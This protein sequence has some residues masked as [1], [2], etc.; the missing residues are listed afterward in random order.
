[1]NELY[2]KYRPTK[3]DRIVGQPTAVAVLKSLVS[4]NKI[5]HALLLT[6]PSGCG[7]TTIARIIRK[8]LNCSKFDFTEI[9]G[10]DKN[11]V[12]D[13][14]QIKTR[15]RAAPLGGDSRVW[16]IDESHKMSPQAQDAFLKSLEDTPSHVYFILATTDPQKLKPTIRTRCTEIIVRSLSNKSLNKLLAYVCDKEDIE[17]SEEVI[18]KIIE[19]SNGSARKALVLLNQI[20]V[21]EDEEEM[22]E[23]IKAT[24]VEEQGKLIA[25]AL[26]NSRTK[27]T[28]MAIILKKTMNEEPESIRWMILGYARNVMLSGGKLTSRAYLITEAFRDNF[29]DSKWTGVVNACYEIIVGTEE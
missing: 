28:E 4:K 27:W 13:I 3:L 19:Y 5:P 26:L 11:G 17:V 16:L 9:D 18:D 25:K 1:M 22:L 14:R 12:D 23:A 6:G 15:M 20:V 24:S 7:K 29:Y 10:A 21:L 8:K 2:K